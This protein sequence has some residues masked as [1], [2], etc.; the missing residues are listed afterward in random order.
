MG[1]APP[2]GPTRV[3]TQSIA[4]SALCIDAVRKIHCAVETGQ[5]LHRELESRHQFRADTW[6]SK[7]CLGVAYRSVTSALIFGLLV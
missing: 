3:N 2:Q 1:S 7:L 4:W 5:E 6:V